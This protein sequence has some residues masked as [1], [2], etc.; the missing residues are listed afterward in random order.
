MIAFRG[1]LSSGITDHGPVYT[2]SQYVM[3]SKRHMAKMGNNGAEDHLNNIIVFT[4]H[5]A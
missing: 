5:K 2:L 1:L 3:L 4:W